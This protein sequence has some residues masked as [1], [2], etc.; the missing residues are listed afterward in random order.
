MLELIKFSFGNKISYLKYN[1]NKKESSNKYL[2]IIYYIKTIQ[3]NIGKMIYKNKN[4]YE[5]TQIFNKRFILS[6]KKRA[7]VIIN[8]KQ[9]DLKESI[10]NKRLT[11]KIKIKFFDIILYL[12]SM[13]KDCISLYSV[14]NF[15][16]INTQYLITIYYLFYGCNTLEYIYD[17]SNWKTNNINDIEEI[18]L[19][20]STLKS[21]SNKSKW[22]LLLNDKNIIS[23]LYGCFSLKQLLDISNFKAKQIVDLSYLFY[24]CSSLQE[25]PD[26]SKWN[27]S[28]VNNISNLFNG[29]SSLK[30]LPD[31]SKWNLFNVNNISNLFNGCSFLKQL[32]DISKWNINNIK[33]ISRLFY[34]CSSLKELP[35]I[36]KWNLTNV[37]DLSY[38]FYNCSS[39][40]ELPDISK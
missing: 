3:K 19:Q 8:N 32:P 31:I 10:A 14:Y 18:F 13:F 2:E 23:K 9:N 27:L 16:N 35:D 15:Q 25:L 40:K 34:N 33:K 29:C 38:L 20:F 24:G 26:I 5:Y 6:N 4:I 39:L 11:F 30:Q 21:L 1:S 36:S 12:D 17:I 22:N 28:N 7:K 37:N